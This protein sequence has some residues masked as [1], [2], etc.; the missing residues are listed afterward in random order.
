MQFLQQGKIDLMIATMNVTEERRKAVG[1]V[2]P[3]YYASGVNVFANRI[4][5]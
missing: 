3:S 1:I 4:S 5:C 2:E